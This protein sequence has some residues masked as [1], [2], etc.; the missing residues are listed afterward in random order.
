MP[1]FLLGECHGPGAPIGRPKAGIPSRVPPRR[2]LASACIRPRPTHGACRHASAPFPFQYAGAGRR[3]ARDRGKGSAGA[4]CGQTR[5]RPGRLTH[6]TAMQ[7]QWPRL[8]CVTPRGAACL[9]LRREAGR[10]TW[11]HVAGVSIFVL[12]IR[13]LNAFPRHFFF[14]PFRRAER[15]SPCRLPA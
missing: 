14:M 15:H 5:K 11:Q 9:D 8:R 13:R 2:G 4:S 12:S 10:Q 7:W 1:G 6:L 3:R